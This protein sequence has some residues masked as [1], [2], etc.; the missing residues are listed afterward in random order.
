MIQTQENSEKTH[1]GP[2]LS[3]LGP[4]LGATKFFSHK[5]S[6]VSH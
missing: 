3:P 6:F 5:T 4:N 1:F 2:D